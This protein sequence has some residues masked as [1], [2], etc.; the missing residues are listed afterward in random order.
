MLLDGIWIIGIKFGI[1]FIQ[2]YQSVRLCCSGLGAFCPRVLIS[3]YIRKLETRNFLRGNLLQMQSNQYHI[4][5]KKLI[6]YSPY[7][8]FIERKTIAFMQA[9]Y[10]ALKIEF[11]NWFVLSLKWKRVGC[12]SGN[13]LG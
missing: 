11:A 7:Y 1:I 8:L 10:P 12:K 5:F 2:L 13:E 6:Q 4:D 3:E 9:T